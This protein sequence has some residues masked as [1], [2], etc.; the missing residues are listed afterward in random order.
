MEAMDLKDTHK[1][2][3]ELGDVLLSGLPC[4]DRSE[5]GEFDI[6]DISTGICRKMIERH[7]HIL[8]MKGEDFQTGSGQL[9]EDQEEGKGL[10]ESY[11]DPQGHPARAAALM[12][13]QGTEELPWWDLTGTRQRTP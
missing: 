1:M 10:A 13:V 2:V 12:R 7:P 9:G 4:P 5:H 11:P 3:E 6:R 8:G